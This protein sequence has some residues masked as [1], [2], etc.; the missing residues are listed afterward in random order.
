MLPLLLSS[1]N[2][3]KPK[4]A[5]FTNRPPKACVHSS[6]PCPLAYFLSTYITLHV[7]RETSSRP[8]LMPSVAHLDLKQSSPHSYNTTESPADLVSHGSTGENSNGRASSNSDIGTGRDGTDS[9]VIGAS[10]ASR[11]SGGS[12]GSSSG[13]CSSGGR[14]ST[15][16]CGRK[17]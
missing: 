13:A 4:T 14:G 15:A 6:Y 5:V 8:S 12:R 7:C 1:T 9:G 16:V 10:G 11:G 3:N 17:A 2:P